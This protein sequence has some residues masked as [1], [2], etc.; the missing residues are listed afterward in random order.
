[1]QRKIIQIYF[2]IAGHSGVAVNFDELLKAIIIALLVWA[3][4]VFTGP[5]LALL[6][7]SLVA[8][9]L[10]PSVRPFAWSLIPCTVMF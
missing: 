5:G 10:G 3:K 1:M 6:V 7:L 9:F 4:F 8:M 2:E